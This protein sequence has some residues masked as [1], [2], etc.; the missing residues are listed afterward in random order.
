VSRDVERR[1]MTTKPAILTTLAGALQG[2]ARLD[3]A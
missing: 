2:N 1:D 3:A